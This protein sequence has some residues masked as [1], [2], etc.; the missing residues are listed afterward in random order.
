MRYT[1]HG[2]MFAR[3]K[4]WWRLLSPIAYFGLFVSPA[5]LVNAPISG[6]RR[7][8]LSP[9]TFWILF[10]LVVFLGVGMAYFFGKAAWLHCRAKVIHLDAIVGLLGCLFAISVLLFM[11]V[12]R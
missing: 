4:G 12:F 8:G 6:V 1:L 11:H 5:Y 3:M 7:A 2:D 9:E 10:S